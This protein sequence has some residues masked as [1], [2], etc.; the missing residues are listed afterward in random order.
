MRPLG[1]HDPTTIGT[2]RLLGVLGGGGM[3]RV[4]LGESRTG[5]RVAIKVV[6]AN[7]VEDPTF[8]RRF[9]REV[10]AART[11]SALYTAAVVDADTAATEPWLATTYIDG[12]SLAQ[13]VGG[14]GPLAPG[15]VLTLAA[16][17]AEAL[18]AI[19]QA[20]L[21]HRDLK[22]S[23]IILS[24]VGPHI[25]DFGIAL[26][27]EV[28]RLTASLVMGTPSYIAP[29]L[30]QGDEA[31]PAGDVFAL[32]ASLAYAATGRHL[33]SD[34]PMH[35]QMM[36]IAAGRF[37]LSS[38]PSELRPLIVRCTS[39]NP[40]DRPTPDELARILVGSGVAKPAPGWYSSDSPAPTIHLPP[41][42]STRLARRRLLAIGGGAGVLAL[43]AG[44]A[45]WAGVFTR[46][47]RP[48]TA[49]QPPPSAQ[50]TPS[51]TPSAPPR[52]PGSVVW[53]A[54]SGAPA[55]AP[56][57]ADRQSPA[58]IVIDRGE[59]IITSDGSR[60][61]AVGL[62]GTQ[63]W[64][65]TLPTGLV[66]LWPWGA[67]LLVS[68][69]RRLWLLD[70]ATGTQRFLLPVADDEERASTGD[71]PDRL[72]VQVGGVAIAGEVVYVGLGTATVA[73]SRQGHQLWRRARP[74]A[75]N[76]VRPPAGIPVATRDRWLVT[77]DPNGALV[78]LGLRDVTD[79]HLQ[80][81][82]QYQPAPPVVVPPGGPQGPGGPPPPDE[83][84]TR[85]EG[86]VGTAHVVI[87][88]VQEVRVV[89]L[90]KG[91][92]VW[93][94]VSELPVAGM[95]L[96][97]DII[98]VAAD[99]LRAYAIGTGAELWQ[100]DLRGARVAVT[101]RGDRIVVAGE[102]GLAALDR[103]G[104]AIWQRPYP[105]AVAD[106]AADRITA[107]DDLA[108]ITFRPKAEQSTPLDVD[109]IAVSLS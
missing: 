21:L 60:V 57:P 32:G 41:T 35:A 46:S 71:D 87:R 38:V 101:P 6:H 83:A 68:D 31:G 58:R 15:A 88:E 90:A 22:P 51:L 19:H 45:A 20:G 4:Y 81:L 99:R 62:D 33:V 26:T 18:A 7:L 36:Q 89:S 17:L 59:R 105:P 12:P 29:E 54:R 37:D 66:N 56:S 3:G 107:T 96:V 39:V 75:R 63:Q 77:H 82:V 48:A 76:G 84:W 13:Q 67:D 11:V 74:D 5:R 47:P 14:G 79:G 92:T 2:Y 72:P 16:G 43:G 40:A 42:R 25:I 86:R 93:R 23:N 70:A 1:P 91:A 97:D 52:G 44:A 73:L 34:G 27:P 94:Q 8:R 80:W 109:V 65:S 30:I 102:Q 104:T 85:S 24:D 28:T 106:A 108:Y 55:V 64:S 103:S 9:E 100:V 98:L 50:A 53:Q 49:W 95:E 69:P 78:N 10:T 61:F